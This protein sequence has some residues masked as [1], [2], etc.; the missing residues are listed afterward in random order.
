MFTI[1]Q[2][3]AMILIKLLEG[4]AQFNDKRTKKTINEVLCV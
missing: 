4:L 1:T 2:H 3:F